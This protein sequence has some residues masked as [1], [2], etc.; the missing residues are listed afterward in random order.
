[1]MRD[2]P[3]SRP[4]RPPNFYLFLPQLEDP[5][6]A[7]WDAG[8]RRA[9]CAPAAGHF[10][11]PGSGSGFRIRSRTHWPD[12]IRIQYG[13]GCGTLQKSRRIFT[14]FFL[15]SKTLTAPSETLATGGLRPSCGSFL[16]S[17]I[18]IR[19][20]NTDPDPLAWLNTDPTRIRIRNHAQQPE[21][22][23]LFL[24]QLEDPDS[25]ERDAGDGRVA[26]QLRVR[27]AVPPA[28][29]IP[30]QTF[31]LP[32][33]STNHRQPWKILTLNCTPMLCLTILRYAKE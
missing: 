10:C 2:H 24:P 33:P 32:Y 9:G 18:R 14:F 20:P 23:Y 13:S 26:P 21:D 29:V 11:L 17:W 4:Q 8:E 27:V 15:N 6:S 1:M 28:H 3:C 19:I 16:P 31:M 25:S 22:F 12:W 7:E 5:D 30:E